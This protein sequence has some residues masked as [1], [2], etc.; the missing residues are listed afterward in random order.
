MMLVS[1]KRTRENAEKWARRRWLTFI[2]GLFVCQ[3]GLWAFAITVVAGDTSHAIVSD[4]DQRAL[5]WDRHMQ[6]RQRSAA[7]GWG[8]S[9][10][11]EPAVLDGGQRMVVVELTDA[12]G[13]PIDDAEVELTLFHQ[14]RASQRSSVVLR[15]DGTG[16]YRG[17]ASID[18]DGKWRFELLARSGADELVLERTQRIALQE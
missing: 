17:V 9:I 12:R 8:A 11:V 5:D 15:S 7:L 14:A 18:R 10:V 2:V 16:R 1:K 4:Y 3:A 6:R 13:R